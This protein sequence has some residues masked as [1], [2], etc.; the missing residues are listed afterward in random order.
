MPAPLAA[1]IIGGSVLTGLIGSRAQSRAANVAAGSQERA[2]MMGIDE[3]RRQF[4][5]MREL[6][7]PYVQQGQRAMGQL[8]P[9]QQAG[10]SSMSDLDRIQRAGGSSI[11]ALQAYEQAG[12][13]ALQEQQALAGLRGEDQQAA[14]IERAQ[15]GGM[16]DAMLQQG[17]NAILQNASATGG[18]RGG[19]TQALLA[20]YRPQF[21]NQILQQRYAQLGG[22]AGAG[23]NVAQTLAGMGGT[24]AGQRVAQ[25]LQTT[26]NLAQM[27]QASAAGQAAQGQAS[28]SNIAN[29]MG[30]MGS[31]Q[32]GAALASGQAQSNAINQF[33]GAAG[34]LM[35]LK[36]LGAF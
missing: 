15:Q 26:Q 2:A 29:L 12:I 16:M 23:A 7:S 5:A 27:G 24:I 32:A 28:A 35:T 36:L 34:Q 10:L 13:Q 3:Q 20:Q 17:E 8:R 18:L 31:A 30:Q 25:G 6:L 19:N 14:A 9:W 21:L 4:D 22:L 33:G 11:G 1:G